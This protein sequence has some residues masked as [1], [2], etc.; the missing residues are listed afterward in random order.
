MSGTR[1]ITKFANRRLYDP[2][3]RRYITLGDIRELV[4]RDI[5]FSVVEKQGQRDVTGRT[6]LQV[7][8][9]QEQAEHPVFSREV[10][11]DAIRAAASGRLA[12]EVN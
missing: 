9:E 8:V 12:R 2:A 6:L 4:L 11:A 3:L 7:L 5:E 10:L 1:K